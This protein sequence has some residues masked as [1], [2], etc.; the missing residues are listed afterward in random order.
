MA[1]EVPRQMLQAAAGKLPPKP[2]LLRSG[3]APRATTLRPQSLRLATSLPSS[4]P[5]PAPIISQAQRHGRPR[6]EGRAGRRARMRWPLAGGQA[7]CRREVRKHPKESAGGT[8]QAAGR[9]RAGLGGSG[10]GGPQGG[11]LPVAGGFKNPRTAEGSQPT[12][13]WRGSGSPWLEPGW[14]GAFVNGK[15]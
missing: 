5:L 1:L 8:G 15:R 11:P 12:L 10:P 13:S 9:G 7:L 3:P 6:L 14:G 4:C 2:E